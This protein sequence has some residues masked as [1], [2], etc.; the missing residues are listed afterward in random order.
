[1]DN[2]RY[3][4]Y[5]TRTPIRLDGRLDG[6]IWDKA[7]WSDR[8]VD[9]VDG[10]PGPFDTRCKCLWDDE[11]L[12]IA[13]WAEEPFVSASLT[14]R[15]SI[16]FGENDLEVFFDGGDTYYEFEINAKNTVY[17]V[18]YIWRDAYKKGGVYDVPE[19]DLI[20]QEARSFGG[21]HDRSVDHFWRGIHSRGDK[22]AF[23][24][25]DYPGL[26]TAVQVDGELN[27][28]RHV[29][30]GWSC[31]LKFP[32]RG[33]KWLAD[34]KTL[35]PRQGDVIRMFL[36]RFE[37]LHLMGRQV[38]CG[39]GLDPIGDGDNHKPELFSPVLFSETYVE[40]L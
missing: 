19:F 29:D 32:W 11:N 33:M 18:F 8:F 35:P 17:E 7:P 30:K 39:W 6:K 1:M 3:T 4:C 21:N 36:G 13:F 20:E 25:W 9:L 27:N 10:N 40:D 5:K 15:D 34:G 31:E 26:E 37:Q 38:G 16:I 22:W 23:I 28:P 14:E 24:H 12:Y 2:I